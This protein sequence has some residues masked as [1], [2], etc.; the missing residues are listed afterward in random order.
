VTE[1]PRDVHAAAHHQG[2]GLYRPGAGTV[3]LVGERVRPHR[4]QPGN[5]LHIDLLQRG[6]SLRLMIMANVWP[7]ALGLRTRER[8]GNSE[9][10]EANDSH[11]PHYGKAGQQCS[12][13]PVHLVPDA[14]VYRL[15]WRE[16]IS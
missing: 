12:W 5:V 1:R 9:T 8:N 7:V 15:R 6:V 16:V 13:L 3:G 2:H 11:R 10:G 4:R 14:E